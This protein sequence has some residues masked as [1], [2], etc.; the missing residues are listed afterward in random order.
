MKRIQLAW[1]AAGILAL[2]GGTI[3]LRR[4]RA[5]ALPAEPQA[6]A[7]VSYVPREW[8]A[9]QGGLVAIGSDV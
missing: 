8:G 4:A 3:V 7:C 1:A 9:A 5:S 2:A 6:S